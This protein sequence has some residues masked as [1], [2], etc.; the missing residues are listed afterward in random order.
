MIDLGK[1]AK[2]RHNPL[3]VHRFQYDCQL[4]RREGL[5]DPSKHFRSDKRLEPF[6]SQRSMH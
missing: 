3:G 2:C 4:A 6:T 5:R 1:S